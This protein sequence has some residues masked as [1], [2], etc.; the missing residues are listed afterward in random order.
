MILQS[1]PVG[2]YLPL[3]QCDVPTHRLYHKHLSRWHPGVKMTNLMGADISEAWKFKF[4]RA[5]INPGYTP[6]YLPKINMINRRKRNSLIA[7]TSD[8]SLYCPTRYLQF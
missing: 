1:R 7:H 8:V 5:P 6:N 2:D 4:R 3:L